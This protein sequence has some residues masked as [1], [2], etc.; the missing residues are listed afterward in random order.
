MWRY[1]RINLETIGVK[2]L[3]QLDEIPSISLDDLPIY[4]EEKHELLQNGVRAKFTNEKPLAHGSYGNLFFT[5]RDMQGSLGLSNQLSNQQSNQLS[6]QQAV[7]FKQPRMA[8]MSL[9]QE[10]VLQYIAQIT[11]EKGGIGWCVPKVFD[12]FWRQEHIWFSMEYIA[13]LSVVEWFQ[14][15]ENHDRSFLLMIAQLCLYLGYLELQLALDHRDLKLDNL[16][17]KQQPCE[18][19]LILQGYSWTLK[20]PFTVVI[21]DFG[22]ACLGSKEVRGKPIVNLGDG[23]LPP[24]DPCPKEGRDLF[25]LLTSFLRYETLTKKL[26]SSVVK[27]V[28]EWLSV[29]KKSY[30]PMA[31]RW[32]TEN[33]TYLVASQREFAIPSCCPNNIL[34]S[35]LPSLHTS[36]H[37]KERV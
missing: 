37:C 9:F 27:Q 21:L 28:D 4:S 19:H 25:Q 22:F 13:G 6:N 11:A 20:S 16:I 29:G 26:S 36:L 8:E 24:M 5:V 7:L 1:E 35:I 15:C 2:G 3:Y 33:W 34:K 17:I 18:I 12:V 32:S 30:G 23:I 10:G 14:H 31:R